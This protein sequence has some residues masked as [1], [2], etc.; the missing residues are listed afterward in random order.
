MAINASR[1]NSEESESEEN[2]NQVNSNIVFHIVEV[3]K[4]SCKNIY[5]EKVQ[6]ISSNIAR[7]TRAHSSNVERRNHS[8]SSNV[9]RRTTNS[10]VQYTF[11]SNGDRRT[12]QNSSNVHYTENL[13]KFHS[14]YSPNPFTEWILPPRRYHPKG[15]KDQPEISFITEF[16]AKEKGP[17]TVWVKNN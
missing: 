11:S 10:Q 9:D 2:S 8:S 16:C 6:H 15:Y 4:I 17:K 3:D 13:N 5:N 12:H 14:K 7:R 1:Q